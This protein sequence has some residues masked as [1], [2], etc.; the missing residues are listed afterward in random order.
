MS[1]IKT[2]QYKSALQPLQ[3]LIAFSLQMHWEDESQLN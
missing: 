3:T 1:L 2:E